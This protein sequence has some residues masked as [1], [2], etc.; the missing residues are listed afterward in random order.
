MIISHNVLF[1]L[2]I[3]SSLTEQFRFVKFA[4][5]LS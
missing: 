5:V 3:T 1:S 4:D 2:G